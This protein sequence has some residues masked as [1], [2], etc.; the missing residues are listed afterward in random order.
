LR[1]EF[2]KN[3][4]SYSR[5]SL[6]QEKI[7]QARN[8]LAEL[9]G[10]RDWTGKKVLDIGFGQGLS[11]CLLAE[12]GAEVYGLDIDPDN[13][14]A[15]SATADQFHLDHM[16]EVKIG[17]IL[18]E[19]V[20]SDYL[21]RGKFDLVHSWGVLHHT[22]N[23]NAAIRNACRLVKDDGLLVISIYNR[24]WSS[25][26]WKQIK[27]LYNKMPS[28]GKHLMVSSLYGVIYIAKYLVTGQNPKKKRRGM[29]FRHDVVDWVGGYP[30]EYASIAEIETLME[31]MGFQKMNVKS[32][33]VPTACNEFTY[34]RSHEC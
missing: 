26:A 24:H 17:S 28:P 34:F 4:T 22:G 15:L 33:P 19:S 6:D 21:Q 29:D 23:M 7:A 27:W 10:N 14:A 16:P 13:V 1:F 20:M 8:D 30:Y 3:W 18:D 11:L 31:T 32:N 12:T 5:T 2:G 25:P 9:L